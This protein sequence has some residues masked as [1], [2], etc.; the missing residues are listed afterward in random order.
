[1]EKLD[2]QTPDRT[3]RTSRL[4]WIGLAM[5]GLGSGPLIVVMLAAAVGISSDPNPNPVG[6]GM[7][8][9]CTFWPGICLVIAGTVITLSNRRNSLR[10]GSIGVEAPNGKDPVSESRT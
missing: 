8:A 4:L 5:L 9:G 6:L 3:W 1:M 2:Y 7:L 10:K